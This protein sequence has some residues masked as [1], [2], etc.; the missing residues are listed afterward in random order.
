MKLD[1]VE[2]KVNVATNDISDAIVRLRPD[3]GTAMQLWFYEDLTPGIAT[4]PLLHGGVILRL[5][6][7]KNGKTE[8]TV[9]LRPCRLSQ[10]PNDWNDHPGDNLTISVEEDRSRTSRT[11]AASCTVDHTPSPTLAGPPYQLGDLLTDR[12][13]R[14]LSFCAT[15]RVNPTELTALGPIAATR[16]KNVGGDGIADLEPRAEL[17]QV[18]RHR[19]LEISVRA[20]IESAPSAR[21]RLVEL[22][23]Q[24]SL[25][26]D[27]SDENKTR[28]VLTALAHVSTP[29]A[30]EP[31]P[32]TVPA[33]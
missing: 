2:V 21:S 30:N 5:R 32:S 10:L 15:L 3:D 16:W 29:P 22:L 9:K 17:W 26:E 7:R 13:V 8:S 31:S 19:Y 33:P 6:V 1:G 23:T 18:E 20:T 14:F 4:L 11:I 24:H 12:Q 27:D 28:R 25:A